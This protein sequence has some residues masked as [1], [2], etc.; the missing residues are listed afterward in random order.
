MFTAFS[1]F[2][3]KV[4]GQLAILFGLEK[5]GTSDI[6]FQGHG[7]VGEFKNPNKNVR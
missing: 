4:T 2:S 5:S 3:R 7:F 6:Y 1:F